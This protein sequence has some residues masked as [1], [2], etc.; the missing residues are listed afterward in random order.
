VQG[1]TGKQ[2]R[3]SWGK[4]IGW[5]GQERGSMPTTEQ[6]IHAQHRVVQPRTGASSQQAGQGPAIVC[7]CLVLT[8][9]MSLPDV[10]PPT[11]PPTYPPTH[12]TWPEGEKATS[13]A[14][15]S[16]GAV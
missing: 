9:R 7:V 6:Y 3:S 8:P 4:L 1:P 12:P 15:S 5:K 10:P 14:S 2:C 11:H 13:C 16:R